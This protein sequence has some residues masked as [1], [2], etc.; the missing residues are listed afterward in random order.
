MAKPLQIRNVHANGC[1]HRFDSSLSEEFNNGIFQ[2]DLYMYV[3]NINQLKICIC[4]R[5]LHLM[6]LLS[7]LDNKVIC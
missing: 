6:R 5:L 1:S 2:R 4:H 3:S 7:A